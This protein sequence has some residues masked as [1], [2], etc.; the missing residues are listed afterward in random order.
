MVSVADTEY[1]LS[2]GGA[3]FIPTNEVHR[4]QSGKESEIS[5]IKADNAHFG[6]IIGTKSLI[7]PVLSETDS[8]RKLIEKIE[9]EHSLESEHQDIAIDCAVISFLVDMLR[10]E[11]LCIIARERTQ[12]RTATEIYNEL[13]KKIF[14]EYST[15]TFNEA[16]D[17][18]HFSKPYFSNIFRKIFGTTFTHYINTVRIA[19][20]I[21]MIKDGRASV[22][23]ISSS[24]GFGTIRSFNRVFKEMTGYTPGTLPA[25]Y[26]FSYTLA[27][28]AGLN[29]TKTTTEIIHGTHQNRR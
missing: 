15:L 1:K 6:R 25:D 12:K 11:D 22:T 14:E 17:Y 20:A 23:A 5:V 4:I 16:A 9:S 2:V 13:C 18:M 28:G 19:A 7:T 24:C 10:H 27:D 29:P 8:L 21:D 3:V 26:I